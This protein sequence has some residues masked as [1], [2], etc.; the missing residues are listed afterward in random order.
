[1]FTCLQVL[2]Y[3]AGCNAASVYIDK[4]GILRFKQFSADDEPVIE[5]SDSEYSRVK[6]LNPPK[7]YTRIVV[8]TDDEGSGFEAGSGDENHTLYMY[9]PLATQ[10]IVDDLLEHLNGFSYVPVELDSPRG[11][12]QLEVGDRFRF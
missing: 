6:I 4:G 7:T 9:N 5:L 12:P 1:G 10:E 3:I 2:G 11:Y 8:Q